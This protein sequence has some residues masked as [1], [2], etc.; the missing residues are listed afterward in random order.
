MNQKHNLSYNLTAQ[1]YFL[2]NLPLPLLKQGVLWYLPTTKNINSAKDIIQF[3]SKYNNQK[4]QLYIFPEDFTAWQLSNNNDAK[5]ILVGSD[6]WPLALPSTQALKK[7]T[8]SLKVGQSIKPLELIEQ[9]TLA[10]FEN[11]P[12]LDRAG[13]W[14][15]QGGNLL[16]TT[17]QG[18]WLIV[19]QG[20]VIE[21]LR[22]INLVTGQ[23]LAKPDQ[24]TIPPRQLPPDP[25]TT[26]STYLEPI[27]SLIGAPVDLVLPK[28]NLIARTDF[29]ANTDW[30][31]VPLFAKIWTEA[32]KYLTSPKFKNFKITVLS[33]EPKLAAYHL[34]L[35]E[36]N[37]QEIETTEA[38]S[39]AGFVDTHGKKIFV[40]DRELFGLK[41]RYT[42]K[43]LSAYDQLKIDEYLV[44]VDHGIGKFRGLTSLVIDD[45]KKD[46]LLIEYA[47]EDKIYVPVEHTD[48][49]SRYL[50]DPN[51]KLERLHAAN[52][53][54]MT[55]AVKEETAILAKELL[56]TYAKRQVSE[57]K[58]WQT[59]PEEQVL[60]H[61][62]PYTLTP[63][64]LKAWLEIQA[65]LSKNTP[66]D[67]LIC[68]DVGFGKTELALRS[69]FKAVLN[70]YQVMILAPTTI[71]AQQHFDTFTE[72]FKDFGLTI[73]LVSRHQSAAVLKTVAHEL[74]TGKIDITIGTHA[75]LANKFKPLNLGLLIID[76]E[77]KFG[78]KQKEKIRQYKP[79]LHTLSLSATPI[80]RS[81]NL[82]VSSL[83]D[84][85]II[86][87]PPSG[88]LSI[89][90]HIGVV[91]N[92][93]IKKA[94]SDEIKRGGQ[95]YY[96][97]NHISELPQAEAR[98]KQLLP[99]VSLGVLHG[100][101]SGEYIAKLMHEF[102]QGN[103]KILLATSIIE[104]GIDLP[105]VNTLIVEQADRFGLSDLYQI[106]G[107]IGRSTR[108]A[109]AYFFTPPKTTTLAQKRLEVLSQHQNLG[110]GLSVALRDLELRGA[111]SILG[112]DQHGHIS[113]IGVHL[114]G[115]M[116]A[117]AIEELKSGEPAET[118]PEV[119]IRLPLPGRI[120]PKLIP[121]ESQRIYL[122]QRLSNCQNQTEL[123]D[124][125]EEIM[126][127]PLQDT[128]DD[129]KIKNLLT[130]LEF[131]ILSQKAGL[132]ELSC[133][134][135]QY[136][137]KFTLRF[138]MEPA[139]HVYSAL[140]KLDN[141]WVIKDTGWQATQTLAA[142]A[143]I[144]W[145]KL[146]LETIISARDSGHH[147]LPIAA[148]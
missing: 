68:G 11:G 84:L 73:A 97:V 112:R 29:K 122:Y 28:L 118:I 19:W 77:Q 41:R 83:R 32:I 24:L 10:G 12:L 65:D 111:G 121:D 114:Y 3:W 56:E 106:R 148:K 110:S 139:S 103:I 130:L 57:L 49:L 138:M 72:R 64:Q 146:S 23:C 93:L 80:P 45:I 37:Y 61:K 44:H 27:N 53:F 22:Q 26:L 125:V 129:Q 145:L 33:S 104:N 15:K 88:R 50:G 109:Q 67:R 133:E 141:S 126:G 78:V 86:N 9:L 62:F 119:L 116:L 132:H 127:R 48:R 60:A 79:S 34:K 76:E 143:W 38:Q 63:D 81:L 75:L 147:H 137:G 140:N 96:L 54:Q 70:G 105:N 82:A 16:I 136:V 85:S 36:L 94:I 21:E 31:D 17:N 40:T 99:N 113:A 128:E 87:T 14:Q 71:L 90:T 101:M 120:E 134:W 7:L 123:Y 4:I 5:I 135:N 95:A 102:D 66:M 142:G 58:P 1:G 8:L 74:N 43:N 42:V 55:K 39:L 6:H 107:R 108:Q 13:W 46:Y 20:N 35:A 124:T 47:A 117:Q 91:N 18:N 51:P 100:R 144:P 69:A 115:Q 92:D 2:A 52:W 25:N 89:K 98:L 131:K 30:L 59:Y